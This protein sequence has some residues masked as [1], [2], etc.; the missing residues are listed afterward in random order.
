MHR[1]W[2]AGL[3][4]LLVIAGVFAWRAKVAADERAA[5]WEFVYRVC[6]SQLDRGPV[7]ELPAYAAAVRRCAETADTAR[8]R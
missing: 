8:D 6:V 2:A 4:V 1:G 7:L 5:R 3:A